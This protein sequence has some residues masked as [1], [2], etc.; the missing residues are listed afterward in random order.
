M[1]HAQ[2]GNGA[3]LVD[4]IHTP[5]PLR[6][7][8]SRRC[9]MRSPAIAQCGLPK[10]S[11]GT[12]TTARAVWPALL[13]SLRPLS[14]EDGLML[15]TEVQPQREVQRVPA[16][17]RLEEDGR[18]RSAAGS[19]KLSF[20]ELTD[21]SVYTG[22]H[23]KEVG[24]PEV[25]SRIESDSCRAVQRLLTSA[26]D[27]HRFKDNRRAD[28]TRPKGGLGEHVDLAHRTVRNPQIAR[29]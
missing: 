9:A 7:A 21:R 4:Y 14:A 11:P 3:R 22:C 28:G 12:K 8:V 13:R 24:V 27:G 10:R 18:L 26:G 17:V 1:G 16:G 29:G 5:A 6:N 25:A 2:L 20:A 19:R 23:T 15:R